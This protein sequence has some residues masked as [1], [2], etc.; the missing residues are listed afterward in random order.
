MDGIVV[1]VIVPGKRYVGLVR[2]FSLTNTNRP[3]E[4]KRWSKNIVLPFQPSTLAA[5]SAMGSGRSRPW[6]LA[7]SSS[8]SIIV[9]LGPVGCTSCPSVLMRQPC[10]ARKREREGEERKGRRK[11]RKK[12]KRKKA[13]QWR[14][15]LPFSAQNAKP[16][17]HDAN[18]HALHCAWR[19][20]DFH[21]RPHV[22]RPHPRTR[23][24]NLDEDFDSDFD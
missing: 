21:D 22:S 15:P 16:D 12:E 9:A 24:A 18:T 1:P 5:G 11:N 19:D 20:L 10:I 4:N 17:K 13:E 23:G 3:P 8:A 7:S 2:D 14:E 6:A